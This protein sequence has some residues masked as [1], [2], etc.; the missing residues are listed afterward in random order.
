MGIARPCR[1]PAGETALLPPSWHQ[2]LGPGGEQA[3]QAPGLP[4]E[5]GMATAQPGRGMEQPRPGS[6]GAAVARE[7]LEKPGATGGGRQGWP[8]TEISCLALSTAWNFW[9]TEPCEV[10]CQGKQ[11]D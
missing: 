10:P 7:A 6:T 11:A 5:A 9:H 1:L 8:H 4:G 3:G 2:E